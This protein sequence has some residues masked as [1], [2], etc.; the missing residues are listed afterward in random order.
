MY[1][2]HVTYRVS[3]EEY[4]IH[5]CVVAPQEYV[6]IYSTRRLVGIKLRRV[7]IYIYIY[8]YIYMHIY[9]YIYIGLT[10]LHIG[11]SLPEGSLSWA[12]Y[13][14]KRVKPIHIYLYIY[15]YIYIYI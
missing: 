9:K 15:I 13:L 14:L 10:R 3:Q 11:S 2:F 5:I 1:A 6:D 7:N 8:I 4:V 12:P